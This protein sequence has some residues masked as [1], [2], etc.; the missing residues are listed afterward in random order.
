MQFLSPQQTEGA[1]TAEMLRCAGYMV[2]VSARPQLL[3]C[4]PLEA[5]LPK[6]VPSF[7][8]ARCPDYCSVCLD[9]SEIPV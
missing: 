5:L 1:A 2:G 3:E 9:L 7:P 8:K 4:C 6:A